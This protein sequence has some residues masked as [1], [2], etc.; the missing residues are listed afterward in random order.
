MPTLVVTIISLP[1]TW[2]GAGPRQPVHGRH[3]VGWRVDKND[4]EFVA[5]EPG[6]EV[7][8]PASIGCVPDIAQH[9]MP[10]EWCGGLVDLLELVDVETE[11]GDLRPVAMHAHDRLG[12]ATDEGLAVGKP[13]EGVM[14][15][16]IADLCL[17]LPPLAPAHPGEGGG[18]GDA[19]AE[20]SQ[21][22]ADHPGEIIGEHGR[23]IALV[24]IDDEG[25][26]RLA[27]QRGEEA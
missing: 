3:D 13:G 21:R 17:G 8:W 2:A 10:P 15:L 4:G 22:D 14:L 20:Q 16:E 25:S 24:E 23:L 26:A 12:Q 11:Y 1:A 27:I 6:D 7:F 9:L 19:G 18:Q 5:G